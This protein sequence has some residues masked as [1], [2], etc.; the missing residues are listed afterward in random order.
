MRIRISCNRGGRDARGAERHHADAG[1]PRPQTSRALPTFRHRA[2]EW[3][4]VCDRERRESGGDEDGVLLRVAWWRKVRV[5][6]HEP[7]RRG[8]ELSERRRAQ[9]ATSL[10]SVSVTR[11]KRIDHG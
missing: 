7:D 11:R 8:G 5:F 2:D 4:S 1:D 9:A 10:T 3:R 6:A